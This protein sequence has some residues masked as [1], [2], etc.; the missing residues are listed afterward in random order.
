MGA[1]AFGM[2]AHRR[3]GIAAYE[4]TGHGLSDR[5]TFGPSHS[6]GRGLRC[7]R[8]TLSVPAEST[9]R[10]IR[11][12]IADDHPLFR[13]GVRERLNQFPG[14]V[15][16]VGEAT[17][18]EEAVRLVQLLQPDVVLIDIAM[19][20]VNGIEATRRIKERWPE[21][22]VL[23]LSVYDDDQYVYAVIEAG[24]A[25]YLLKTV[26]ANALIDAITRVR[27]G[28]SVLAPSVT[29]KVMSRFAARPGQQPTRATWASLSEREVQVLQ[30]AAEGASNKEI[31]GHLDLSIRTVHAHMRHIFDKLGVASRTEAV[32][33]GVRGGWLTLDDG[34]GQH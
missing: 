8:M 22:G 4:G 34:R 28:D 9:E 5:R 10:P 27:L 17:D 15:D 2:H 11:L 18:G 19:P 16:V 20:R 29:R 32:V 24:A 13:A 33:H 7:A 12:L 31:A 21:V 6:A 23:V 1:A 30:L 25:G 14:Q 26:D 3:L